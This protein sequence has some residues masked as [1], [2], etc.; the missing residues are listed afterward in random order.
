MNSAL[1]Y[2]I[3]LTL[4]PHIGPVQAK[5][6]LQHL[7]PEEIFASKKG[8]LERIEGIGPF[9]ANAIRRFRDF[10]L[11]EK[12]AVF[13]QDK[14]I[15]V[16]L[17]GSEDYP[18]RLSHCFDPPTLL[19]VK[20]DIDLNAPRVIGV[21]GTRGNTD[22]GKQ[23]TEKFIG[24]LEGSQTVIISGLAYGIDALAHRSALKH[25][26]PTAAV[27][28]HGLNHL[29]PPEHSP[30]AKEMIRNGGGIITEFNTSFK[31][32]KHNF[33]LR[34]RVV[35]GLCDAI[36]VIESGIKGGSMITAE[37]ANGYN[38]DVFAFPG[39]AGDQKSAGCNYLIRNNKAA[40]VTDTQELLEAMGWIEEKEKKPRRHQRELF[41][42][43][44][45]E[46]HLIVE[47]LKTADTVH[48]DEIR[49][50]SGLTPGAVASGL[51]SLEFKS[52]ISSRPGKTYQLL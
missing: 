50:R 51:L 48:I 49:E 33:P 5:I 28:A 39:R 25:S 46:E 12:E 36:V 14:K 21:I 34:N 35:A 42:E 4:V 19:Y 15:R 13:I 1:T 23:V 17:Y 32:D 20:G 52:V 45:S 29:Y 7:K 8:I 16:L 40:L 27:L 9:R 38:R 18:Q 30:I 2:Q 6:L 43:L 26:L 3:A 22:Y 31:P 44:N 24:A 10:D 11:A 47:I 37:L 41:L